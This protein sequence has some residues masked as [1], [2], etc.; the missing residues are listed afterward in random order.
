MLVR[1]KFTKQ[2]DVEV[3][4]NEGQCVASPIAKSFY[5]HTEVRLVAAT[6]HKLYI[7]RLAGNLLEE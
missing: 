7:T 6:L 5:G 1:L 2:R 3:G 4:W